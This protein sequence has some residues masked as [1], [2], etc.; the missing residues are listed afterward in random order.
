MTTMNVPDPVEIDIEKSMETGDEVI[1]KTRIIVRRFM[2]NKTAVAGLVIFI[3]LCLFSTAGVFLQ[4][5]DKTTL[6]VFN[7]VPVPALITGLVPLRVGVTFLPR[8]LKAC[9]PQF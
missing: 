6:D 3:L 4:K 9:E 5:W 1:S 8:W 7:I 2:R